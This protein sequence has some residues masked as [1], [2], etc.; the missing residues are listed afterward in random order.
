M[1]QIS[2]ATALAASPTIHA[3]AAPLAKAKKAAA[4]PKAEAVPAVPPL[5]NTAA[6]KAAAKATAL[7]DQRR[8]KCNFVR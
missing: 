2:V 1:P 6:K 3:A 8:F 7:N 5:P 4:A